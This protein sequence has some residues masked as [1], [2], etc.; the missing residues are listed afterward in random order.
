[1]VDEIIEIARDYSIVSDELKKLK[2]RPK[3]D[4]A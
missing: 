1:M 4:I 3:G 2:A